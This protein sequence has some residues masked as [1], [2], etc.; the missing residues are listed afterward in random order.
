MSNIDSVQ[1][2]EGSVAIFWG[3]DADGHLVISD[4]SD[5][6]KQGCGK[7]FAQFPKGQFCFVLFSLLI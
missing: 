7:S 3:A 5:V 4:E 6:V 1:D 2:A